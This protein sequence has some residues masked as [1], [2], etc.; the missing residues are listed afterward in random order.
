MF[1]FNKK[2][3]ESPQE[4]A[5]Y[6][7]E[8]LTCT[9]DNKLY[10]AAANATYPG[11]TMFARD[12]NLPPEIEEKYTPGLVI[13]EKAFLDA[14]VRF[15]GMATTHRFIILSNHMANF[16]SLEHGTNWGLHVARRD[17]HFKVLGTTVAHGKTGIILLHLPDDAALWR[18]FLDASFSADR[19][20]YQ[21]AVERFAAKCSSPAIPELATETWL[22]RCAFPVGMN[23]KGKLWP[24]QD[25]APWDQLDQYDYCNARYYQLN[26]GHV[27]K[28]TIDNKLY[29]F[30]L[31][32]KKWFLNGALSA[33]FS[34][35]EVC[36]YIELNIDADPYPCVDEN[37]P[38]IYGSVEKWKKQ[39]YEGCLL[40]GAIG[41]ALGYPIEFLSEAAIENRFGGAGIRY[42]SQAGSP[43]LIS[44]DTQMT[45]FA[46]NALIYLACHPDRM[47]L[48]SCLKKTYQEWYNTQFSY[49]KDENSALMWVYDDDRM[50]ATRAPGN[51]CLAAI[52]AFDDTQT[53]HPAENNSKGCGT[54]MRAAPFGLM[55]SSKEFDPPEDGIHIVE[56]VARMDA[57]LTHGHPAA[58]ASSSMLAAIV[59][60]LTQIQLYR[61][62]RL[63]DE[64]LQINVGDEALQ[65]MI[66]KAIQ[67]ALDPAIADLDGIH[68]LGE[69]WVGD[70][71]LAI[72]V[73]CAVRYQDDF[74]AAIRTAVNHKG[75]SDS[76]GAICGN[77]LGAW[78]GIRE[79]SE[80]FDVEDLELQDVILEIADD[81]Y[82]S[83]EGRLA[84]QGDDPRWD[85]HYYL[86]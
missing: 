54:V 27:I 81:M 41:D 86:R 21:M 64:I 39:I 83:A 73:F 36:S 3:R 79:V 70:E 20:V 50:H 43:A 24:L 68:A 51:T 11:L 33:E 49:S 71:A 66:Q 29:T 55:H 4:N 72:A 19:Q 60:R 25:K 42:L 52:S 40:G 56:E 9:S 14:S 84:K 76:T 31:P 13:R 8:P 18:V 32:E 78:L 2:K 1:R 45:L 58:Q 12:V 62:H 67:L 7:P 5:S 69:G 37:P 75:D 38:V 28:R 35:G 23:E 80:A 6:K 82:S 59:Y 77:I 53:V 57:A 26:P 48:P 85:E 46:A 34:G 74:A 61:F 15:M 65:N 10:E 17:S 47:S 22:A 44:D 30:Y 63:E 16:A